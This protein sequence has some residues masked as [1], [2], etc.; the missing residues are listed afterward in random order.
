MRRATASSTG[1]DTAYLLPAN[2]YGP[3][4]NFDLETSHVIP[5]LIRKMIEGEDEVVLWGDGSPTREFLYV[6]DAA[7]AFVAAAERYDDPEPV[8]IGTGVGDLDPRARRDDRG[9]DRLRRRDRLGHLDAE[10]TAAPRPRRVEGKG[11]IRLHREHESSRRAR[12]DDRVVPRAGGSCSSVRRALAALPPLCG[13]RSARRAA[14]ARGRRARARAGLELL[15]PR[16][17]DRR[18]ACS[19]SRSSLLYAVALLIGGRVFALGA[20]LLFIVGPVILA[21]RY[22][23]VGGRNLDY[24]T[25]YRHDVLPTAFGLTARAGIGAACLLLA[26]AWL[27][28]AR[29]PRAAS[30]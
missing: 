17:G 5:A 24:K 15:A 25:V 22:F 28:L 12:A 9:A 11:R 30:G 20:T 21:K 13:R 16:R 6:D 14:A 19:R 4:D 1:C 10:R 23:I 7:E 29:H 2:L 8:N 27:V 18:A 26:S 3:R